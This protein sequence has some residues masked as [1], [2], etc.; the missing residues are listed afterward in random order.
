MVGRLFAK[1][2]REMT[3]CQ[4]PYNF[5]CVVFLLVYPIFPL[6]GSA[7]YDSAREVDKLQLSAFQTKP[8]YDNIYEIVA[9]PQNEEPIWWPHYRAEMQT[10]LSK[11]FLDF[12][13]S[14]S[15]TWTRICDYAG[16]CAVQGKDK[17]AFWAYAALYDLAGI[18]EAKPYADRLI[19]A[20]SL[21][22]LR[23]NFQ[24]LVIAT[25]E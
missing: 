24:A 23:H 4:A 7:L 8:T 16:A 18:Q 17:E 19:P 25:G 1:V 2:G 20:M 9:T 13:G 10:P 21:E 12:W 5:L 15:F 6:M 3:V 22:T 11:G 14:C